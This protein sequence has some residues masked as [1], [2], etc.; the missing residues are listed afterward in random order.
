[1]K[2]VYSGWSPFR[3]A[4]LGLLCLILLSNC[5]YF[6]QAE[7]KAAQRAEYEKR[8]QEALVAA[9]AYGD[10]IALIPFFP[11]EAQAAFTLGIASLPHDEMTAL[12]QFKRALALC[13]FHYLAHYNAAVIFERDANTPCATHH[14]EQALNIAPAFDPAAL[15]LAGLLDEH[16]QTVKAETLLRE[17]LQQRSQD[18]TLHAALARL[19]AR[20][21]RDKEARE[22]ALEA[23]RWDERNAAAMLAMGMLYRRKAQYELATM[24][25]TESMEI[26]PGLAEALY[27]YGLIL[28]AQ[29]DAVRA[30]QVFE[31]AAVLRPNDPVILNNLGMVR[32]EVGAF[33][34][35]IEVLERATQLRPDQSSYQLNLGNALRGEQRYADAEKAYLKALEGPNGTPQALFNLGVLYLDND[36]TG[37]DVVGRYVKSIDYLRDYQSKAKVTP[38]DA[39]RIA[40]FI[41]TAEKQIEEER[42]RLERDKKRREKK[43]RE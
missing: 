34:G 4:I 25:L 20:H 38:E 8:L 10:P 37:K 30:V 11:S 24:A 27:E 40:E 41:K 7:L 1:M 26:D 22:H 42:R 43:G 16:G 18:P 9:R 33:R 31:K 2:S 14:F 23:L 6:R 3:V 28:L 36:M 12:Q 5:A 13:P 35:A 32:N 39:A 15:G 21:D 17:H 29:D 19:L